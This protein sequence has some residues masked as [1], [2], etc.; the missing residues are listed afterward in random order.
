MR[1]TLPLV[2]DDLGLQPVKN[3][4]EPIRVFVIRLD[5]QTL[6]TSRPSTMQQTL[7]LPGRPSVAVLPFATTTPEDE[8]LGD[9]ISDDVI[10]A[11]SKMRWLFVIARNSSFACKRSLV[12][13]SEELAGAT[14]D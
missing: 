14:L 10:T 11:L 3:I 6:S 4:D 1:K 12:E 2:F 13:W 8:Y 7:P 9:G 5:A